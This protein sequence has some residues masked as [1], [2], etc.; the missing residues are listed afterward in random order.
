MAR[1]NNRAIRNL[2]NDTENTGGYFGGTRGRLP[3]RQL[4]NQTTFA[5]TGYLDNEK[6]VRDTQMRLASGGSDSSVAYRYPVYPEPQLISSMPPQLAGASDRWNTKGQVA[7][8][9]NMDTGGWFGGDYNAEKLLRDIQ[10]VYINP[11]YKNQYIQKAASADQKERVA[12]LT[13]NLDQAVQKVAAANTKYFGKKFEVLP[14][15]KNEVSNK[16]NGKYSNPMKTLQVNI[17]GDYA[18]LA[19]A[20][21]TGNMLPMRYTKKSDANFRRRGKMTDPDQAVGPYTKDMWMNT[22]YDHKGSE[23]IASVVQHEFL[24]TQGLDH[25]RGYTQDAANSILSYVS[26]D[27]GA[28]LLASDINYYQMVQRNLK[29]R[30]LAKNAYK[31]VA[32]NRK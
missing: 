16:F 27:H 5:G 23:R 7:S 30:R 32:K 28:K 10:K 14:F 9:E 13:K 31:G 2:R 22:A 1:K 24:H 20:W 18:P 17:E 29:N 11:L 25:P 6:N 12:G 4:V 3:D 21:G 8:L 26:D 15:P 19:K